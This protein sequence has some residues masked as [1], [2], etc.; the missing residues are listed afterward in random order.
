MEIRS[1]GPGL[2][3]WLIGWRTGARSSPAG[4]QRLHG[5]L[6]EPADQEASKRRPRARFYHQTVCTRFSLGWAW[7]SV[8]DRRHRLRSHRPHAKHLGVVF[9]LWRDPLV[10]EQAES[11][12]WKLHRRLS[13]TFQ[14]LAIVKKRIGRSGCRRGKTSLSRMQKGHTSDRSQC[15][16]RGARQ[17]W[18]CW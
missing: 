16:S 14:R 11:A 9:W 2:T 1:P 5:G 18:L 6:A 8:Q 7:S 4:S 3:Q 12:N 17:G 10:G 15:G 13:D